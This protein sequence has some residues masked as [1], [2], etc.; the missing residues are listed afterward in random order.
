M[1][2]ITLIKSQ[3][4][5]Q[6]KKYRSKINHNKEEVGNIMALKDST[7]N[8]LLTNTETPGVTYPKREKE[9]D[10]DTIR[11]IPKHVSI[12]DANLEDYSEALIDKL[13]FILKNP[14]K[15]PVT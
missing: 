6:E 10:S 5:H 9:I 12:P 4:F 7:L 14:S 1:A 3:L 2:I 11:L 13:I 8:Q 15:L